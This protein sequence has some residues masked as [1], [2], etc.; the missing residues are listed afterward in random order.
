MINQLHTQ[1][2][3]KR[4][5]SMLYYIQKKYCWCYTISIQERSTTSIR[6]KKEAQRV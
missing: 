3:S 4:A 5:P 1:Y 2:I 6:S